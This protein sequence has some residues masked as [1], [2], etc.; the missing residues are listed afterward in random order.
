MSVRYLAH[1]SAGTMAYVMQIN[2]AKG[3]CGRKISGMR[4]PLNKEGRMFKK[5]IVRYL[6]LFSFFLFL[7]LVATTHSDKGTEG[8]LEQMGV[9]RVKE[10]IDAHQFTLPDLEGRKRS[11]SE[12]KGK[13]VMLNFW[14]TW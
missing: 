14:T 9:F 10:N 5:P 6:L 12:F 7:L 1:G 8:S 3:S 13:F 4:T 2:K 11:L